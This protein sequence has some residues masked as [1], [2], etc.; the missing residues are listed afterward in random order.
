MAHNSSEYVPHIQGSHCVSPRGIMFL[1]ISDL[2][3]VFGSRNEEEL[4]DQSA[5]LSSAGNPLNC[6]NEA[7]IILEADTMLISQMCL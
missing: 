4:K 1:M 7:V 5:F 6:Q 2:G 3:S